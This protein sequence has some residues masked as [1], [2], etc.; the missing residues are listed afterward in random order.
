MK[1]AHVFKSAKVAKAESITIVT[2]LSLGRLN[3]LMNQC[4][5]WHDRIAAV[6]YSPLLVTNNTI[7]ST[8]TAN[9][10]WDGLDVPT[11][12]E[13]LKWWHAHIDRG[14]GCTLDLEFAVEEFESK[15]DPVA[16]LYPVNALRNRAHML[17]ETE[18][19]VLLDVDF[20][21]SAGLVS[22]YRRPGGYSDMMQ[23]LAERKLI[24]LPAFLTTGKQGP[25]A[26]IAGAL[27]GKEGLIE[28]F[29]Q[30]KLD[31]FSQCGYSCHGITDYPKWFK[32][33][34]SYPVMYKKPYEP[35]F[36]AA[37]AFVPWYDERFRG[38]YQNKIMH[39]VHISVLGVQF[40][41]H[42][43]HYVI[44]MFH[45]KSSTY[46]AT[47]VTNTKEHNF[48]LAAKIR[49]EAS[50]GEFLPVT[51]FYDDKTWCASNKVVALKTTAGAKKSSSSHAQEQ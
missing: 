35:Y 44:H 37:K 11:V 27:M 23:Q 38:Y 17:A 34:E 31:A 7:F 32:A 3:M 29:E 21:P 19:I 42:P 30:K 36:L 6:V 25:E 24:V 8:D 2:Q 18:A 20:L 5:V 39:R 9:L 40:L 15:E 48:E 49:N 1:R 33:N 28:A 10:E 16:S 12:I 45:T 46:G 14:A 43:R 4:M 51:S 26:A 41:V 50:A 22:D 13:K 47:R